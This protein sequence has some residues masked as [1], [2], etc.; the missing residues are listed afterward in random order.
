[1]NRSS[2]CLSAWDAFNDPRTDLWNSRIV[3]RL[4]VVIER[5]HAVLSGHALGRAEIVKDI[6]KTDV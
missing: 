1:M 5:H 2:V 3:K 4:D 6:L